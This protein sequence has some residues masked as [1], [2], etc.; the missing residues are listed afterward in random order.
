MNLTLGRGSA[1]APG[2]HHR[3]LVGHLTALKERSGHSFAQLASN[4]RTTGGADGIGGV[5]AT[6]LKRVVDLKDVPG[7]RAVIA[8]VRACSVGGEREALRLWRAA[9]AED[10]GHLG[11]LRAPDVDSIRT[12]AD[13]AAALAAAY[14]RAGAPSCASSRSAPPPP[15][16][17][18]LCFYR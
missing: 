3:S 12:Q 7:E 10:R 9:R 15:R 16:F 4:S 8:Y 11:R 13:L 5:S 1:P 2:R 6:T 18:D 17:P 14:E